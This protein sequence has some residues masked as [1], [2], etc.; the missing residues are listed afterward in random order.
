MFVCVFHQRMMNLWPLCLHQ[1][2]NNDH[3]TAAAAS[4][5]AIIVAVVVVVIIVQ[6]FHM[7]PISRGP[8]EFG[9]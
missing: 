4:T 2:S 6:C 9:N 1:R 7:R 8:I 3:E 5:A